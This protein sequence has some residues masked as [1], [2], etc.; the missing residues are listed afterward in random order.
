MPLYQYEPDSG[1]CDHCRGRFE[2]LQKV[3][4]PPLSECPECGQP[5]H[6]VFS[7]FATIKS[8]KD[9]LSPKNLERHGFTQ[10]QRAG[11]GHYEKTTGKGPRVIK[12]D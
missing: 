9:L 5:C 12:D 6:R 10:Y 1:G 8:T 4:D 11:D 3:G 7:S 2:V